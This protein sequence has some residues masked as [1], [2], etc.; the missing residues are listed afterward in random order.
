[1][2]KCPY[3]GMVDKRRTTK[4]LK[5][6]HSNEALVRVKERIDRENQKTEMLAGQYSG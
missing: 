2:G 1:M 4:K 6:D 3:C 5:N